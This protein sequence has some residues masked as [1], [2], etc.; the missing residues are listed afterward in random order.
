MSEIIAV[1]PPRDSAGAVADCVEVG[2]AMPAPQR[3][4]A[5]LRGTRRPHCGQSRL[6]PAWSWPVLSEVEGSGMGHNR[7]LNHR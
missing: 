5:T 6:K 1:D 4:L 7:E 3:Q 2:A